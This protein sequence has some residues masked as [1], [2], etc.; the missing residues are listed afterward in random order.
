MLSQSGPLPDGVC[1]RLSGNPL[2]STQN[3]CGSRQTREVL[4]LI[5]LPTPNCDDDGLSSFSTARI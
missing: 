1:A 4:L 2:S 5:T 3:E